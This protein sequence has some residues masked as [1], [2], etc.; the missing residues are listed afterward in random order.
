MSLLEFY[1]TQLKVLW[2]WK[3]GPWALVRRFLLTSLVAAAAFLVTD[4]ILPGLTVDSFAAV[5]GA[6]VLVALFNALIRTAIIG[7]VTPL[8]VLL[9]GVLVLVFQVVAFLFVTW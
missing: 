4:W 3:G 8:S 9:A 1:K 6:V 7:L 5:I 2:E